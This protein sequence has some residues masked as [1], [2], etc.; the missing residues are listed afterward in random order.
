MPL[1]GERGKCLETKRKQ[2]Y[3]DNSVNVGV[4]LIA[5]I[6]YSTVAIFTHPIDSAQ[7]A[8]PSTKEEN[9]SDI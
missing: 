9:R 3:G 7:M 1:F 5:E 8:L 4:V 6:F 2:P